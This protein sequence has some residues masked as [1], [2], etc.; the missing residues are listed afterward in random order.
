MNPAISCSLM[1]L[2]AF[3]TLA[4]GHAGFK[5]YRQPGVILQVDQSVGLNITLQLGET[6]ESVTVTAAGSLAD[7]DRRSLQ[8]SMDLIPSGSFRI[9]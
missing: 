7:L 4:A 1:S 6:A 5:S 2:W 9:G 8:V 3:N